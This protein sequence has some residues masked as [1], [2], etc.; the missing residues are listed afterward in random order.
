MGKKDKAAKKAKVPSI[1][2]FNTVYLG[3]YELPAQFVPGLDAIQYALP[4][5]KTESKDLDSKV[6][7]TIS[8]YGIKAIRTAFAGMKQK[9]VMETSSD[10]GVSFD[11]ICNESIYRVAFCAD[12]GKDFCYIMQ[13]T[14]QDGSGQEVFRC[15]AFSCKSKKVAQQ[16]ADATA[17]A[18]QRVFNTLALLK[19]KIKSLDEANSEV[20][21]ARRASIAS[22]S[23]VVE[24]KASQLVDLIHFEGYEDADAKFRTEMLEMAGFEDGAT[25]YVEPDLGSYAGPSKRTQVRQQDPNEYERTRF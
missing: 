20:N 13:G 23:S 21:D 9:D 17:I 15:F 1:L 22:A 11:F 8:I 5:I 4:R 14:A 10:G 6:S 2:S 16:V 24:S 3:C 19:A 12:V 25:P 18:C 7:L